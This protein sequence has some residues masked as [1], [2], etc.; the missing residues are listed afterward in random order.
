ME[1]S[2]AG[3]QS[4]SDC[5]ASVVGSWFGIGIVVAVPLAV[6]GTACLEGAVD[7]ANREPASFFNPIVAI[8]NGRAVR[9]IWLC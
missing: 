7:A 3:Q 1:H 2:L 6:D 8:S 5:T 4:S 9:V